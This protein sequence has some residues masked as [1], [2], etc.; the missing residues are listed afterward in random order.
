M[1]EKIDKRFLTGFLMI[2]AVL[3][4]AAFYFCT[5]KQGFH[6]DELYTY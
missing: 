1:R 2:W 6:E 5:L 4:A 3:M